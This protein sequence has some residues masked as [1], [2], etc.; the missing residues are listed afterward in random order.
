[1]SLV[2]IQPNLPASDAAES[3]ERSVS[4]SSDPGAFDE[5]LSRAGA[6]IVEP[7]AAA[8]QAVE[9]FAAG[10]DGNLHETLLAVDKA[11]ISL[12]FMVS[13][14]NRLLDTYREIMQMGM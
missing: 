11:D 4:K 6:A 1:M 2:P 3:A 14:R 10:A 5:A 9:Q 13:V 12:K 8:A 7:Q